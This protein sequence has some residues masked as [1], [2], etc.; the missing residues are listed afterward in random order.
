MAAR[1]EQVRG[2]IILDTDWVPEAGGEAKVAMGCFARLRPLVPEPKASSTTRRSA[3]FI[4]RRCYVS[5]AGCRS[6]G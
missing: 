2:R 3:V 6:T 4:A 1:S 5:T